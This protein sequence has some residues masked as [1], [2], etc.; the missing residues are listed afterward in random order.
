M[1]SLKFLDQESSPGPLQ[2]KQSPNQWTSREFPNTVSLHERPHMVTQPFPDSGLTQ[3]SPQ[4]IHCCEPAA[5]QSAAP[6]L[7]RVSL[8]AMWGYKNT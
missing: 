8:E 2:W 3:A 7:R 6:L 5:H 1:L 4:E